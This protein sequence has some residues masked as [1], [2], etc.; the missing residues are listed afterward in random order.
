MPY[1][2]REKFGEIG[3]PVENWESNNKLHWE[4]FLGNSK[5]AACLTQLY[6]RFKDLKKKRNEKWI[7]QIWAPALT[8]YSSR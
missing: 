1:S 4:K 5:T 6:S 2:F 3:S 8:N 7:L